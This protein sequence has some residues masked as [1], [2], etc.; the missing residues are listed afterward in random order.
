MN[1]DD[2]CSFDNKERM[3]HLPAIVSTE[4]NQ[5]DSKLEIHF[6]DNDKRRAERQVLDVL[7][8]LVMGSLLSRIILRYEN[9]YLG[10]FAFRSKLHFR[11]DG[12]NDIA[13]DDGRFVSVY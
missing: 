8:K 5:H 7:A 11:L 9:T 12:F 2:E 4:T 10:H 6:C 13:L 1:D 3:F